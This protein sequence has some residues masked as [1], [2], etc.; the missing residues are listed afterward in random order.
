MRIMIATGGTG[1]HVFPALAV[2]REIRRLE[3]DC[4]L[5]FIGRR[6]GI[7]RKEFSSSRSNY[8]AV[9]VRPLPP[10]VGLESV[11]SLAALAGATSRCG[12]EFLRN[13][14]HVGIGFGGYVSA[15]ALL[16]TRTLG[17]PTAIHEQNA[18][19]GKVNRWLSSH[20]NR[21]FLSYCESRENLRSSSIE[22]SGMPVREDVVNRPARPEALG[23]EPELMTL[24]FL[25]GSQGAR[26]LCRAAVECIRILWERGLRFQVI[27]HTGKANYDETARQTFPA[28]TAVI[29]FLEDI[30]NAYACADLV[31]ARAGAS[32]V[33]EIA[34]NGLPAV[35]VPYPFATE[36]HQRRNVEPLVRTGAARLLLDQEVSGLRLAEELIPLMRK[37]ETRGRMSDAIRRFAQPGAASRIA[38]GVLDLAR[39]SEK[40]VFEPQK[41]S[42]QG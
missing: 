17:I 11:I 26:K 38:R 30:G 42:G 35:F 33:A 4:D 7:E 2:A 16:A 13:R 22:V 8:M 24:F 36:D 39:R 5:T 27:L 1:G 21:V 29:G 15:P 9:D 37:S 34:A 6:D 28:K 20:V 40:K 12:W 10:R 14:P 18:V 41:E 32:S 19:V 3:P 25:G 23:L 31:V